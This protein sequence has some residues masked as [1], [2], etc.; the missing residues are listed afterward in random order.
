[1]TRW[2]KTKIRGKDRKEDLPSYPRS[3]K[4]SICIDCNWR[5]HVCACVYFS[6]YFDCIWFWSWHSSQRFWCWIEI[7]RE[8]G[9]NSKTQLFFG[10]QDSQGF[11]KSGLTWGYCLLPNVPGTSLLRETWGQPVLTALWVSVVPIQQITVLLLSHRL[12]VCSFTL[13]NCEQQ[14]NLN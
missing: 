1:M 12:C 2:E 9:W 3:L 5:R 6:F 14:G 11:D 8:P 4:S 7:F 13:Y 10:S